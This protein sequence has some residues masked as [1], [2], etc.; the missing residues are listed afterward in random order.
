MMA[1][2]SSVANLTPRNTSSKSY[3]QNVSTFQRVTSKTADSDEPWQKLPQSKGKAISCD[4]MCSNLETFALH[5]TA[6][7]QQHK[8]LNNEMQ[9]QTRRGK[10]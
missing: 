1:L 7:G 3:S 8:V 4:K 10:L 9:T 6:E 2:L 5:L